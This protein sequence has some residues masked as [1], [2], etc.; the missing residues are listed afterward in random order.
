[1]VWISLILAGIWFLMRIQSGEV[2]SP[3]EPTPTPTRVASS[4]L[5]E[6]EAYFQAGKL[7]DPDPPPPAPPRYDAIDTYKRALEVEPD[8]ARVW[9]DLARIQTYSTTMLSNDQ[10]RQK[11]LVEAVE[12]VDQAVSLDTEDSTIQAIRAFVYDW[13][14][15][16][17][18]TP[19]SQRQGLLTEAQN[20]ALRAYQLNHENALALAYYAEVLLDQQNWTQAEQYAVQAVN[21]FENGVGPNQAYAMDAHRVYGTVLESVGKYNSAIKEYTRAAEI[22][23]N[24]SFLYVFIGRN[25]VTQP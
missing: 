24:L 13:Y 7:D 2:R 12:S 17:P 11:R 6:A 3:L 22:N 15:T 1:M 10:D 8:N 21:L 19:D 16:G 5:E 4:F 14:A 23:P 18:L 9:A 20:A 25:Y